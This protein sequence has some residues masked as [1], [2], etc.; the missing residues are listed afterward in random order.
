MTQ[1]TN[2]VST[3]GPVV[4]ENLTADQCEVF[5]CLDLW[6]GQRHRWHCRGRDQSNGHHGGLQRKHSGG[7]LFQ[8][9]VG[10]NYYLASG[11]TN[12]GTG[13]TNIAPVLLSDLTNRTTYPPILI[14][15]NFSANTTLTPQAQRD[16]CTP[17]PPRSADCRLTRSITF[18]ATAP[19]V[20]GKP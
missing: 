19:S 20:L 11:S 4:A 13:T 8:T 10:G 14:T 2:C 7:G 17:L 6:R 5:Y 1:G 15:T 18:G 12:Q 3:A 9:V 16:R